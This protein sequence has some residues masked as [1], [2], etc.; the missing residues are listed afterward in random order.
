[1][2]LCRSAIPLPG[3]GAADLPSLR[4][5]VRARQGDV[6]RMGSAS[7]RVCRE[8]RYQKLFI[9]LVNLAM[10]TW[11]LCLDTGRLPGAISIGKNIVA[12]SAKNGR[13][14]NVRPDKNVYVV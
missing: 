6:R 5:H 12:E 4:G 1:M 9:D 10:Q 14:V 2:A 7:G 11:L 13:H 3:P 8:S